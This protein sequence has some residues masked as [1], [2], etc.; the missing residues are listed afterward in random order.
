[1]GQISSDWLKIWVSGF[2]GGAVTGAL[3]GRSKPLKR[4]K[5]PRPNSTPVKRGVNEISV[6][7]GVQ[8]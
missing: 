1:M 5:A 3:A 4:F 6:T 7:Y 2:L 8:R